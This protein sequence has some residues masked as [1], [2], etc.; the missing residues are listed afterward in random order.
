MTITVSIEELRDYENRMSKWG[1]A[2]AQFIAS[3]ATQVCDRGYGVTQ[4]IR[5]QI[6]PD[7][8]EKWDRE[9]PAPKLIPPV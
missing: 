8:I 3:I 6:S 1:G 9:N 5:T 7:A 4:T 2:R